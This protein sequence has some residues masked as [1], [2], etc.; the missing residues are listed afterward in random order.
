MSRICADRSDA[1][2]PPCPSDDRARARPNNVLLPSP[3]SRER[4]RMAP[5]RP[6]AVCRR[7]M[8][9]LG[10]MPDGAITEAEIAQRVLELVEVREHCASRA[11]FVLKV[12]GIEDRPVQVEDELRWIRRSCRVLQVETLGECI[13]QRRHRLGEKR[14]SAG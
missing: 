13:I 8:I 2:C 3:P 5:R 14:V 11:R 6:G 10:L 1:W 12:D 4:R 9:A 7:D